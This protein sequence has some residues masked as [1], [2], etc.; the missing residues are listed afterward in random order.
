MVCNI[1]NVKINDESNKNIQ[2]FTNRIINK[3]TTNL[4]NFHYNVLIANL[5]DIYNFLQKIY[6]KKDFDPKLFIENYL[7]ILKIIKPILPH[8]ASE[9]LENFNNANDDWPELNK[10][11]LEDKTANIVIQI[12]G[13]KRSLMECEKDISEDKL[14]NLINKNQELKKYFENKSILKTI[15]VKNKIINFIIKQ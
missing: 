12:N 2:I 4:E 11:F 7:K 3:I 5:H 15:F 8:L 10:E 1:T 9:C 13:K 14:K 6:E